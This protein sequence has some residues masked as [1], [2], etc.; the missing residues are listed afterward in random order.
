[1]TFSYV[2]SFGYQPCSFRYLTHKYIFRCFLLD[3]WIKFHVWVSIARIFFFTSSSSL[4]EDLLSM[5]NFLV[6]FLYSSDFTRYMLYMYVIVSVWNKNAKYMAGIRPLH[7]TMLFTPGTLCIFPLK[8]CSFKIFNIMLQGW[9]KKYLNWHSR[10]KS[11]ANHWIDVKPGT[12]F[13]GYKVVLKP[14]I[15]RDMPLS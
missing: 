2:Y 14:C 9:E 4:G 12:L 15:S 7:V 11:C 1:M 13:L 8:L 6:S 5:S 10:W 3:G